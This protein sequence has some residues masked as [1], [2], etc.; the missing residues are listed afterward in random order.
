MKV[1]NFKIHDLKFWAWTQTSAMFGHWLQCLHRKSLSRFIKSLCSG[2]KWVWPKRTSSWGLCSWSEISFPASDLLSLLVSMDTNEDQCKKMKRS[3][4]HTFKICSLNSFWIKG[5]L[6]TTVTT[7]LSL[8]GSTPLH[9][10]SHVWH[11]CVFMWE[12][13]LEVSA[14]L[15]SKSSSFLIQFN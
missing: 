6:D 11:I 3:L 10:S 7:L 14:P 1:S 13:L 5:H 15:R 4:N 12:G 2:M 9:T 8:W